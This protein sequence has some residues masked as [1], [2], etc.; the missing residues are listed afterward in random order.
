MRFKQ[1]LGHRKHLQRKAGRLVREFV[2]ESADERMKAIAATG[3]VIGVNF[4]PLF[5]DAE[6]HTLDRLLDHVEH[7]VSVA[8]IDHIGLGPDFIKEIA[9]TTGS[10]FQGIDIGQ[11]LEGTVGGPADFP[12]LCDAL[13]ERGF[14]EEDV[15]KIAGLNFRRVLS[16]EIG[17]S[18]S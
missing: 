2:E 10:E 17:R 11:V 12:V 15:A 6:T 1:H 4:F 13:L 16:E 18:A 7:M 5:V 3:G 14:G 9:D 8:G